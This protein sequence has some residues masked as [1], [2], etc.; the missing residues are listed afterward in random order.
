MDKHRSSKL[1]W[2]SIHRGTNRLDHAQRVIRVRGRHRVAIT[3]GNGHMRMGLQASVNNVLASGLLQASITTSN[4]FSAD[5]FSLTFALGHGLLANLE[6]WPT[7]PPPDV[8][9]ADLGPPI[10]AN[11]ITGRADSLIIDPILRTITIEGR[12]L[13]ASLVDSYSQRNFVNQTA[14]E[15]VET[16]A[17]DHGLSAQATATSGNVGRYFGDGFTKLSLGQ[18]SR[19]RSDWDL[20]AQLARE[21]NYDAFVQGSALVFQP[22]A[23]ASQMSVQISPGDVSAMR[24]ERSFA[25]DP[26]TTVKVQSWNSQRV[27]LYSS[28]NSDQS[29]TPSPGSAIANPQGYL[30]SQSNLTPSQA[31]V[32]MQQYSNEVGRLQ[33]V[34]HIEMPWNLA[35]SARSLILLQNTGTSFDGLYQVDCIE[36]RYSSATGSEQTVTAVSWPVAN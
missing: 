3:P 14:S 13:S 17:S 18:S 25:I 6:P 10:A 8:T 2:G 15:I 27:A 36:R 30:F 34:L 1:D 33:T 21:R 12:D 20:I 32:A 7:S 29:V 28:A 9:V 19:A 16:I 4:Y 31:D 22:A 26:T 5:S 23:D 11:L 35:I 24:L